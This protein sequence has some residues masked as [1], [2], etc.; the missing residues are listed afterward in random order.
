M[1]PPARVR[2]GPWPAVAS[3]SLPR[4][5]IALAEACWSRQ[6]ASRPSANEVLQR[7]V[8]ML[9]AVEVGRASAGGEAGRQA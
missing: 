4:D 5:Y 1:L 2:S 8:V 7:L 9:T 6:A 3:A